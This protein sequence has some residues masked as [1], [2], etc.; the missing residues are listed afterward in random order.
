[1]IITYDFDPQKMFK[2]PLAPPCGHPTN[3]KLTPPRPPTPALLPRLSWYALLAAVVP[4]MAGGSHAD[5]THVYVGNSPRRRMEFSE[6]QRLLGD[7]ATLVQVYYQR[8]YPRRLE[9][10]VVT[11][12]AG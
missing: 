6:N 5:V 2:S 8:L 4:P 9:I 11:L 1:M 7:N 10:C 3:H 12:M